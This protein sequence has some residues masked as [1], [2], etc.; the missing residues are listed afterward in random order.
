MFYGC[1]PALMN[2][3]ANFFYKFCFDMSYGN[4]ALQVIAMTC[5]MCC[6]SM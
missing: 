4:M 3:M 5:A 1:L 2:K 6:R